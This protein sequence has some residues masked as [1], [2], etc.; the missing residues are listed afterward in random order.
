MIELSEGQEQRLVIKWWREFCVT[1]GLDERLLF[2]IPNGA[3][4]AG[5]GQKRGIQM[6]KMKADGLRPGAPDLMLAF[7]KYNPLFSP[8]TQFHGLFIEM[9]K[10]GGKLSKEQ[11]QFADI[12]R[13]NGYNAIC[14]IGAKEAIR[15]IT[16]YLS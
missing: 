14:C 4:L 2:S 9:K 8:I 12:L 5:N 10:D 15:A 11:I 7:P 13:R 6:N 1:K 16:V 3:V